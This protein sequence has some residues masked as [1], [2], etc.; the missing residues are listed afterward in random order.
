MGDGLSGEGQTIFSYGYG[1]D[2]DKEGDKL[3]VQVAGKN[4]IAGVNDAL[5]GMK[6]GGRRRVLV[7]PERGWKE[8]TG[9]CEEGT[10]ELGLTAQKRTSATARS[11]SKS[12]PMPRR[13]IF[14]REAGSR[15]VSA[16]PGPLP[17]K[18]DHGMS[19][20][21]QEP[22]AGANAARYD[23]KTRAQSGVRRWSP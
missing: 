23:E 17:T 8:Q 5:L 9:A 1:E 2:E 10:K 13:E 22:P 11:A 16:A 12:R 7:R 18:A 20:V 3:A 15:G 14:R 21:V 6:P 4:L 19:T